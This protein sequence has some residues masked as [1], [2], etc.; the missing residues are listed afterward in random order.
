[1]NAHL[2]SYESIKEFVIMDRP[3]TVE[4]GL[5]T[6]TLKIRRKRVY[7]AF[8]EELEG[9]YRATKRVEVRA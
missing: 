1:V 6:P 9:L 2:A 4:G 8:H 5:L 7:E 3:L